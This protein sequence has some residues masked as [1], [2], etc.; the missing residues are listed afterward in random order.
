MNTGVHKAVKKLVVVGNGLDLHHGIRS[1]YKNFYNH[2]SF[3]RE[4]RDIYDILTES[5][6]PAERWYDFEEEYR[7]LIKTETVLVERGYG[8][9][10]TGLTDENTKLYMPRV[11]LIN[12]VFQRIN[13]EFINY[14]RD[15]YEAAK[16]ASVNRCFK[17]DKNVLSAL[18]EADVIINFNYT[19]TLE[20]LYEIDRDKIVHIHGT[21]ER[22]NAIIGHSNFCDYEDPK[23]TRYG[24]RINYPGLRNS[25]YLGD[26]NLGVY[27]S[28]GE[29]RLAIISLKIAPYFLAK[30]ISISVS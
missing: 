17:R 15:E 10:K 16:D 8:S 12:Y 21:L 30:S 20:D 23:G 2:I 5:F 1:K 24:Y 28:Q 13:I 14:L 22:N 29:N 7:V 18:S 26:K 3:P 4:L 25:T 11:N 9:R 27:G 6:Y 19:N